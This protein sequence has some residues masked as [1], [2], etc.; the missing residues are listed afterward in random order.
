[1]PA[2]GVKVPPSARSLARSVEVSSSLAA[3]SGVSPV[4][5]G[6]SVMAFPEAAATTPVSATTFSA[7]PCLSVQVATARSFVPTSASAKV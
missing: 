4:S 5:A 6:G 3:F 2:G 1:M 7:V